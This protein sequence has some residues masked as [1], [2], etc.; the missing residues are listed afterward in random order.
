M[1]AGFIKLCLVVKDGAEGMIKGLCGMTRSLWEVAG[2]CSTI[3]TVFLGE[4]LWLK[5]L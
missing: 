4:G 1:S 5:L 3:E 2:L